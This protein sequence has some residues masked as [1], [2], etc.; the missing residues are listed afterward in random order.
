VSF[1]SSPPSFSIVINTYD[2]ALYLDDAIR[3]VLQL[4]YPDFEL[5]VVNG[6]STDRTEEVLARWEGRIKAA[7]CDEANLSVSRNVGI[8]QAAGDIV[9]FLDDDAVP[10]P[11]WLKR[12]APHYAQER[13]GAIGGF[14][15]DNTGMRWQVRKT[16]CDRFG[17]A[18]SVDDLFDERPLNFA[19]TPF[20][21]S[22]LGT[23]SSFRRE[24]L[25]AIGGFDH[26][27]A[28]LLDETDVCLRLV[29]AHWQVVYER[30]ALVFH[31]FAE[32]H[33]RTAT[34]KPKT[35]YPSVVSKTYFIHHHGRSESALRQA[36]ALTGYREELLRAN[37][38]LADHGD[39]SAEQPCAAG[40]RSG[41]RYRDGCPAR[42]RRDRSAQNLG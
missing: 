23:N 22:L 30:E 24:A 18:H 4:D 14:T 3:G 7:R 21:P 40:R 35:L 25:L 11:Q 29:D 6:P 1:S 38:W 36:E 41:A 34:R 27:F 39:I 15:V 42:R 13:V 32:S 16:L 20:Y 17:N 33:V 28:Y 9:A 12:L 31:Q 19:G 8:G 5:I 10:H 26:S 37:K 2:R